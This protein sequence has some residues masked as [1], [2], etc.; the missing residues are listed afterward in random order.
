MNA[1]QVATSDGRLFHAPDMRRLEARAKRLSRQLARQRRGSGRRE[2][3][4]IRLAKTR[5]GIAGIRR[6][7]RHRV[8]RRIADSAYLVAVEDLRVEA[9]TRSAW[10][11]VEEP[12][13]RVRQKAGLN[14]V[15]SDTGWAQLRALL[16]YKAGRLMAVPAHDTSRTCAA[17]GHIDAASRRSQ[18][19]L[20]CAA[21]NHI[22][23]VDANAARNIRRRGLTLL[24]GEAAASSGPANR[25]NTSK[26]AA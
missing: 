17:C 20:H 16:D 24:H 21:C 6:D 26:A 23:H 18:A 1:G 5:R 2:R 9:M 14:R 3:T 15:V 22:T 8:S 19:V 4:R 12:G 13:S 25:E 7:W 10:G 11:T